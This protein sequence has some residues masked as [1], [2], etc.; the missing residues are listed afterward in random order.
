MTGE[1]LTQH[2]HDPLRVVI[3]GGGVAALEALIALQALAPGRIDAILVSANEEFVYRPLLVGEPFGLGQPRRYRLAD[4]CAGLGA[5]LVIDRVTGVTPERHMLHT[6]TGMAVLYDVL[7]VALGARPYPAFD[8]GT[9]FERELSPE[10]FDSVLD[11]LSGGMAP[12]V[13]IVV[14][15]GVSW[16]LPAYE[17]ALMTAAWAEHA[18]PDRTCV[19]VITHEP[20]P[21]ALFGATV[22][23][24]VRGMLESQR[25]ALRCGVHPDVITP[26]A[27]RLGGSWLQADRIVSLPLLSGPR[28]HG[29]PADVH[30][31]IP[32]DA[33]GRVDRV[34]DV[35]AAGDCTTFPIKQGG[36]AAQQA[37]AVASDLAARAGGADVPP[38][39]R[40]P[41]LRGLLMTSEGAR[42]LRA[43]LDDPGGTSTFAHEPLWWPPSKIA[44]RWL[45]PYLARLDV[46]HVHEASSGHEEQA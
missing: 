4:L 33:L 10:D 37:D 35:Y 17:L 28:L 12:H 16:T 13:A 3:A 39:L 43:E 11:D 24:G 14:P 34:D 5:E 31:F 27:L 19:T 8:N 7:L 15:D 21:L 38:R 2:D 42:Y 41:V 44:T 40:R 25:I 32:C 20:G 46:D 22:S 26:T 36:L 1:P 9:T 23:A 6:A 45:A 30:G 18:H 29:L